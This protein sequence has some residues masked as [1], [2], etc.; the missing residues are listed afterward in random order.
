MVHLARQRGAEAVDA[1]ASGREGAAEHSVRA[2]GGAQV[3]D[4]RRCGAGLAGLGLRGIAVEVVAIG[5]PGLLLDMLHLADHVEPEVLDMGA[6]HPEPA[7]FRRWDVHRREVLGRH[8]DAYQGLPDLAIGAVLEFVGPF[9]GALARADARGQALEGEGAHQG[10]AGEGDGDARVRRLDDGPAQFLHPLLG[11]RQLDGDDGDVIAVGRCGKAL[12]PERDVLIG[13]GDVLQFGKPDLD[14]PAR[15][16][17]RLPFQFF[18]RIFGAH[19]GPARAAPA[20]CACHGHLHPQ[21]IRQA[22]GIAERLLPVL[23]EIGALEGRRLG[24]V[25]A[26][27]VELVEA[28]DA[29]GVHPF[30]VLP[31]AVEAHF[32]VH[33]VPPDIGSGGPGRF[34][35]GLDQ[36]GCAIRRRLGGA[37]RRG[38]RQQGE[39]GEED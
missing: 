10:L 9:R 29:H 34:P 32:A 11:R 3:L 6:D 26:A 2:Q 35:K 38:R 36:A 18:H 30:Q 16:L 12:V 28:R 19:P 24:H 13:A 33:P 20:G 4:L 15:D 21:R 27:G 17:D 37:F 14:R 8:R 25:D 31:D 39:Q 1:P 7:G 23:G 5:E 22:H